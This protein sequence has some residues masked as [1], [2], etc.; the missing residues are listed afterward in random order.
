MNYNQIIIL[1]YGLI[2]EN[3]KNWMRP[4]LNYALTCKI[5]FP[6][7]QWENSHCYLITNY[8]YPTHGS[9]SWLVFYAKQT[10]LFMWCYWCIEINCPVHLSDCHN[11]MIVR[12]TLK[13]LEA[14]EY[15]SNNINSSVPRVQKIKICKLTVNWLIIV[16]FVKEIV[17]LDVHYSERQ[18]LMG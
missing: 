8:Q 14:P 4:F 5:M 13:K 2:W 6:P 18:G 12:H 16:E 1:C 15:K 7:V 10:E 9:H 3:G 17:Y 11:I